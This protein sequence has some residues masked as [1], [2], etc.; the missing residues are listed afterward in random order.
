MWASGF[1]RAQACFE[2]YRDGKLLQRRWT[3]DERTQQLMTFPVTD[4]LRGG[5]TM[6][7]TQV[8]RGELFQE[9]EQIEEIVEFL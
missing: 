5:F 7:V 2:F 3:D 6:V 1:E 9:T 8:N 4:D